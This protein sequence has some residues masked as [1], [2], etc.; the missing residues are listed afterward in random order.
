MNYRK[1]SRAVL[2][3]L[4]IGAGVLHF[5]NPAPFARIVPPYLPAP[6]LLVYVSG[7]AELAGGLGLLLPATRRV[8][9]YGLIALLIAVFPANVY[10]LQ[11]QGAGMA[12]PVWALWVRLPLQLVL[13]AWVWWSTRPTLRR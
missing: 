7:L 6:L 8:A 5:V 1:I 9:G 4:F 11:A 10:M 13:L 3:F 12:V 2:A